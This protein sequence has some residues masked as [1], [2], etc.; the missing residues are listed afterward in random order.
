MELTINIEKSLL[1]KLSE[2]WLI[3]IL[4]VPLTI[5]FNGEVDDGLPQKTG[6]DMLSEQIRGHIQNQVRS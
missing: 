3:Y 1:P 5:L 4:Y 6:V 2:Y